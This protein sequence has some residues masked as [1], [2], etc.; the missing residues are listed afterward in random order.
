MKKVLLFGLLGFLVACSGQKDRDQPQAE[1][2]AQPAIAS[3]PSSV[4]PAAPDVSQVADFGVTPEEFRTRYNQ[5]VQ[6]EMNLVAG[7][8]QQAGARASE[9]GAADFNV[10]NMLMPEIVVSGQAFTMKI[11]DRNIIGYLNPE[12]GHLRS[13]SVLGKVNAD[14]FDE[15][16]ISSTISRCAMTAVSTPA[17][18]EQHTAEFKRLADE[19]TNKLSEA[20][21]RGLVKIERAIGSRQ[22]SYSID[23][24]SDRSDYSVLAVTGTR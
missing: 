20:D 4:S 11:V 9:P 10:Q 17:E 1:T 14:N 12:T 21:G 6:K 16:L 7:Q 15:A 5:A 18:L 23:F 3:V 2:S 8:L 13:V 24:T 22:Y 19:L